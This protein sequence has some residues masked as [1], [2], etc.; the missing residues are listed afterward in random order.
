VP[1]F[2]GPA[3]L[4]DAKEVGW[5]ETVRMNASEYTTIITRFDVLTFRTM[6]Q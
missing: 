3:R 5:K 2:T 1:E 6:C 4:P